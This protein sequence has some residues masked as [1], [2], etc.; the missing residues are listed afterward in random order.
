[1]KRIPLTQGQF[2]LVDDEDFELLARFGWMATRNPKSGQFNATRWI[3]ADERELSE[4]KYRLMHREV[5]MAKAGQI[6]DHIDHEP[7]NNQKSN[8]RFVTTAQ[9]AMNRRGP[10][11]TCVS[12]LRGVSFS[13]NCKTRKWR[14]RIGVSGKH[15]TIGYYATK[16]EARVAYADANRKYFGEF[17]GA[18]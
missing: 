2:A 18:V 5:M 16:E 10:T 15:V 9:N 3:K 4:P 13:D 8:L 17:G 1:M 7:L 12:K 11:K 14:A 6:V